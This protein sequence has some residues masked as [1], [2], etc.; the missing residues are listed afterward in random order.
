MRNQSETAPGPQPSRRALAQGM[1]WSV[2]V[3]IVAAPV[4][5]LAASGGNGGITAACA[6]STQARFILDVTGSSSPLVRVLFSH[7]GSGTFSVSTPNT[8][9]LE[10]ATATTFSYLV[11]TSAGT[12]SGTATVTFVLPQNGTATIAATI[13]ATSGQAITGTT[14]ASVTKSRVGNSAN[15]RC[16]AA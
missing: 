12:A 6:P 3:L 2:P 16:S 15:Y 5:A 7:T 1:A 9:T 13:S 11:P 8:W 10:T 14:S 4:P